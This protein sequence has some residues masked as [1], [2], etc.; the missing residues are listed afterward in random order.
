MNYR[1]WIHLSALSLFMLIIIVKFQ[2]CG[3]PPQFDSST[4]HEDPEMRIADDWAQMKL[5]FIEDP[6][7]LIQ[8]TLEQMNFLGLCHGNTKNDQIIWE[9]SFNGELIRSGEI[10][11]QRGGF[12]IPI[13]SLY[14]LECGKDYYLSA[15][16]GNEFDEVIIHRQC[17]KSDS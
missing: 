15:A 10:L 4:F 5:S 8:H 9:V 17:T 2:N 14:D 12:Q 7:V 16:L 3:S 1:R 11:C 6:K 13:N